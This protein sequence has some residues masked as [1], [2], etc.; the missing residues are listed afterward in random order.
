MLNHRQTLLVVLFELFFLLLLDSDFLEILFLFVLY[1][2]ILYFGLFVV[3]EIVVLD[4]PGNFRKLDD[5]VFW[6][7]GW[8]EADGFDLFVFSSFEFDNCIFF[9]SIALAEDGEEDLIHLGHIAEVFNETFQG[10][11]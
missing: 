2:L 3:A 1:F 9:Y 6:V 8:T 11:D 4:G 7:W 10:F 5:T